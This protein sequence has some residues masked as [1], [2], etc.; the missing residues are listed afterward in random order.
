ME[1]FNALTHLL[2]FYPFSWDQT[3]ILGFVVKGL[4]DAMMKSDMKKAEKIIFDEA[5]PLVEQALDNET[6][7]DLV[8][9]A[10]W[11]KA[12]PAFRAFIKPEDMEK[13]V[14]EV[15]VNVIKPQ[16]RRK[17]S[18]QAELKKNK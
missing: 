2:S 11:Q 14:D 15:Y 5:L 9:K 12:P 18:V 13:L 10:L 3:I 8:V 7:R 4:F 16:L 6:K 17:E 1:F